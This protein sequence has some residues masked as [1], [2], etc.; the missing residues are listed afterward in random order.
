M[1]WEAFTDRE[2][3]LPG[4]PIPGRFG[5]RRM[6]HEA[7]LAFPA[8]SASLLKCR[9]AAEMHATLTQETPKDSAALDIGTLTHMALLEPEANW[10]ARFALADIPINPRTQE[11]Y[12]KDTK[13]ALAAVAEAAAA[14]PGKIVVSADLLTEYLA[15]CRSL[16]FAYRANPDAVHELADVETEVTGILWHPRW[17]CWVK[18][19]PD[20]LPRH[21]RHLVDVKT[22]SR[23]VADFGKDAWQFGYYLQAAWYAECHELAC[24]RINIRVG[25]FTFIVLSKADESRYPRPPMCR[26]YDVPMDAAISR[27]I[28][29]AK[30]ALGLPEG[31]SRVD[32]FLDCLRN[33]I[34]AGCPTEE[35]AVRRIWPAYELE[36]GER[37]RWV[38]AD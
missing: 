10:R 32:M 38:L 1:N 36:A 7:Y 20:V 24:A 29:Q 37:G 33:H 23:H 6:S 28:S 12:G 31:F 5:Y 17:N 35:F 22:S 14:N 19:R 3:V 18:W 11:A 15:I 8:L 16:A 13:K 34:A 2:A 9:T 26:V 4:E 27:G 21:C 25:K 30:M